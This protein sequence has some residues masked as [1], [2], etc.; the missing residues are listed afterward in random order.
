[1]TGPNERPPM[2]TTTLR[3]VLGLPLAALLVGGALTAHAQ[4]AT[5]AGAA[6]ADL[7]ARMPFA[8]GEEL[9]YRAI[10]SRFGAFGTGTM[11]IL[12]EETIRGMST[13]R[14]RFDFEGR[15][16]PFRVSDQ[17]RSWLVANRMLS[18]RYQKRERSPL[19]SR[20]EQV[21]IYPDEREWRAP[22]GLGGET[23]T[24]APLDELSFLYFIRTLPLRNGESHAVH[25]HFDA[26]RNPVHIRVLRREVTRVPAGEFRTVVVEMR[27]KDTKVFGGDGTLRLYLTDDDRRIPV[28]I[29][30]SAPWVGGTR[31]ELVASR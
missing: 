7:S 30:S 20:S 29:E 17:T 19:G 24:S 6:R 2:R 13:Y 16:G 11:S 1:M 18:V 3:T 26:A 21:E 8:P 10:S 12:G 4:N 15:V 9:S 28:L 31:L 5:A 14:L 27:V 23:P 22:G 25:R